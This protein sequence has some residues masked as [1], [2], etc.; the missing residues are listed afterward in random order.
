MIRVHKV[1]P[2]EEFNVKIEFT[3]GEVKTIDLEPFLRGPI[4]E[5][6]R[7]NSDLFQEIRVDEEAG[8]IYWPN[9]ADIDPDVLYGNEVPAWRDTR[10]KD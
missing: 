2:L 3:N 9:G 7:S 10:V 8:T 6:I 5:S 4:F 1:E